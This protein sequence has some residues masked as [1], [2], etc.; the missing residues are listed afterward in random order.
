M[1]CG[2]DKEDYKG[3]MHTQTE[4]HMGRGWLLGENWEVTAKCVHG[5]FLGCWK[6]SG[7]RVLR[8][9]RGGG[10]QAQS[11]FLINSS[12]YRSLN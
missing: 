5:F 11:H 9:K 7:I 1:P 4:L 8:K 6:C 3:Y 12:F 10:G 2:K